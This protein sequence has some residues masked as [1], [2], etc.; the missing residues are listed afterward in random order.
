MVIWQCN[1]CAR[2]QILRGAA[3]RRS[4]AV[5]KWRKATRRAL[6]LWCS[7][8]CHELYSQGSN[9]SRG[10]AY[11]RASARPGGKGAQHSR[12]CW[13]MPSTCV[14]FRRLRARW[15][16]FD[17]G[18][19][20][21]QRARRGR[22]APSGTGS[23]P[24]RRTASRRRGGAQPEPECGGSVVVAP[25]RLVFLRDRRERRRGSGRGRRRGDRHARRPRRLRG[26]SRRR[27]NPHAAGTG[28]GARSPVAPARPTARPTSRTSRRPQNRPRRQPS[29]RSADDVAAA[30]DASRRRSAAARATISSANWL[31]AIGALRECRPR[32]APPP[33]LNAGPSAAWSVRTPPHS[34]SGQCRE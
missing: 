11:E 20:R 7:P 18:G 2:G 28:I 10:R 1:A 16:R 34:Q 23:S 22:G 14:S 21:R 3:P 33:I 4:G 19:L 26:L 6:L 13:S 31:D 27:G 29:R 8:A 30:S 17:L 9:T 12:R 15:R 5:Q 25:R 32:R 24:K